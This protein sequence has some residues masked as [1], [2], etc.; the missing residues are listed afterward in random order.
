MTP[1]KH[2]L[3]QHQHWR[4]PLVT[5][6]LLRPII[7]PLTSLVLFPLLPLH[8]LVVVMIPLV[9]FATFATD[10]SRLFGLA[11]ALPVEAVMYLDL[12]LDFG[13]F[14]LAPVFVM[15]SVAVVPPLVA[16]MAD[17]K[18]HSILPSHSTVLVLVLGLSES[19]GRSTYKKIYWTVPT[20]A[21]DLAVAMVG[22]G[23]PFPYSTLV[24]HAIY[25]SHLLCRRL[26]RLIIMSS[27]AYCILML[28]WS[29][30]SRDI[31]TLWLMDLHV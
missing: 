21:W 5:P 3:R 17:P 20:D 7:S 25:G 27:G 18:D 1:L 10:S 15:T 13:H 23:V 4:S 31:R 28:C 30:G 22:I 14:A 2:L 12:F 16:E 11:V 29:T 24:V 6:I 9:S 19:A 8:Y 26:L